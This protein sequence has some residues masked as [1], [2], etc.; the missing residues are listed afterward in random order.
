MAKGKGVGQP[1]NVWGRVSK[2]LPWLKGVG[3]E[4]M[5]DQGRNHGVGVRQTG[6]MEHQL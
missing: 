4:L 2:G 6:D 5:M 3:A 1:G